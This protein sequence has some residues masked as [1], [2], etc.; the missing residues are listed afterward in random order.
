L[1]DET[2]KHIKSSIH[3]ILDED[4]ELVEFIATAVDITERKM[5]EIERRRL[6]SLVEQAGDLMAIADLD[7]GTP[8]YLN[9][10]RSSIRASAS[11]IRKQGG[12]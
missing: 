3:P 10:A 12:L 6:A 7:G 1:P 4:G 5:A 2:V 9:K 8:I 11:T